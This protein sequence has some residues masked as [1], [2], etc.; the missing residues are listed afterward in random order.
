VVCV[1]VALGPLRIVRAVDRE[2]A[3]AR[4][5][6]LGARL[7]AHD[8]PGLAPGAPFDGEW[9]LVEHSFTIA[10]ATNLAFRHP[11]EAPKRRE[12]IARWL[13]LMLTPEVRAFDTARWSEDAFTAL[14][15]THGHVGVLGHVGWAMGASCLVG[16]APHALVPRLAEGLSRRLQRAG[17]SLLETYPGEVYVP[18]NL[19]A[20]A[21]LALLR[22][23]EGRGDDPEVSRFLDRLNDS[24]R[25][26]ANGL[27]VFA[28][29]QSAR[30]SGAAWTAYFL[31]FVD[32][33]LAA[34]QFDRLFDGFGAF[35]GVAVREWP[36]GTNRPGD[37]DSGPLLFGLSPSATGFAMAGPA[38]RND[39]AAARK[40]RLTA[41]TV[42]VTWGGR[43]LLSPLVGDAIVLAASTAT[44]WTDVFLS[45]PSARR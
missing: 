38:L 33:A 15:G 39:E 43:F 23:C 45:P 13:D 14:D 1:G 34:D 18:D 40:L 36:V 9:W 4:L 42:G 25:D 32:P 35:G 5:A 21:A 17:D 24:H 2:D 37:V 31:S 28:P 19:V 20:A 22:R 12:E 41:E 16:N 3:I 11:S 6:Y 27:F 44:P 30:G 26:P 10:A 7:E 8:G 29:G